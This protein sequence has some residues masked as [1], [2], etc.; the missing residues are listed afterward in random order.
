MKSDELVP[1][2]RRAILGVH[3]AVPGLRV[4]WMRDVVEPELRPWRLGATMFSLFGVV[5]LV[6]A[7]IGLYSVV[8][9]TTAQRASEI[10][11]RVALGARVR[12]LTPEQSYHVGE[13]ERTGE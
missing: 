7:S 9:F 12:K 2:V 5:A 4:Q 3:V 11:V 13:R 1:G 8:A 10:A 6:I